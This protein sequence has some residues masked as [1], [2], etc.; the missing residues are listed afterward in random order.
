MLE[1]TAL[2]EELESSGFA[3]ASA[4][5]AP[6]K[7]EALCAALELD[8]RISRRATVQAIRAALWKCPALSQA[9]EV[10]G[11]A[12]LATAVLGRVAFPIDAIYFDKNA[13]ANWVVPAHQDRMLPVA[14][15]SA[16][17]ARRRDGIEYAD[18]EPE[19]LERLVALRVHFDAADAQTGAL[20]VVPGSHAAGVKSDAELRE[21]SLSDFEPCSAQAG[22]VFLMRPLLLHRSSPFSGPGR[23]RVL[24]IVFASEPPLGGKRWRC[25]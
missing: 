5:V 6:E 4:H 21:V 19:T 17:N 20:C 2:R 8:E 24:H 11:L 23:R 7:L 22:D 25:V 1:A 18:I 9:L 12:K 10:C 3:M 14:D 15:G 13:T 16:E